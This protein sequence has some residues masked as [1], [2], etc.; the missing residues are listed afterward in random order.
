MV[1]SCPELTPLEDDTMGGLLGKLVEVSGTY[2]E[3][4]AA[5]LAK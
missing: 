4:R 3:C 5:A 1:A 2:N